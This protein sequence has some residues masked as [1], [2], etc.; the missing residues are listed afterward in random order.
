MSVF[1]VNLHSFGQ[2]PVNNVRFQTLAGGLTPRTIYA[3]G[4]NKINRVLKDGDQF[5]DSN[6]WK[7]FAYPALPLDQAWITVV[8]DDGSTYDDHEKNGGVSTVGYTLACAASSAYSANQAAILS[9]YG[10]VAKYVQIT[11]THATGL[12]KIRVNGVA[13]AVFDLQPLSTHIFNVGDLDISLIEIQV[14]AIGSTATVE[15]VA[16]VH[17]PSLS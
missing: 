8:T 17:I 4:P 15:I 11:N 13:T 7:R 16:G 14:G 12:V 9:D 2:G 1:Q 6:Y 3:M 10:N 5:T